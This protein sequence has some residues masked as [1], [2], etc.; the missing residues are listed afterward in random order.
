MSRLDIQLDEISGEEP[1]E[2]VWPAGAE[3]DV[4]DLRQRLVRE[5][6]RHRQ[7]IPLDLRRVDG[8]PPELVELLADMRNY[9]RSKSKVLSTGRILP[10]L[11]RAL[12]ERA[13]RPVGSS[14]APSCKDE[15]DAAS[16]LARDIL[17]KST[18]TEYD[19]S[20]AKRLERKERHRRRRKSSK[21]NY[22]KL[23]G[24]ILAGAIA[25]ASVEFWII[26]QEDERVY[27][28]E[29]TYESR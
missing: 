16:E 4:A 25:A 9:A 1:V 13:R 23:A 8:A 24:I 27:I 15:S 22:W 2:I 11:R 3:V 7:R 18:K 14:R 20:N 29:K 19:L 17:N 12:E 6:D 10:E 21:R 28:P 26:L 5:I